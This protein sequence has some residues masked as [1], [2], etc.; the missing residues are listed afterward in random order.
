[1]PSR[2]N[3]PVS[4]NVRRL[5]I[6]L[7]RSLSQLKASL[8]REIDVGGLF[9]RSAVVHKWK[10]PWRALLLR[11]SVAWRI[12]DLISQSRQLS[13][14]SGILGARILLRSAFETVAVLVYLNKAMRSVVK[15]TLDFHLFSEKTARL[16]LGSRDKTTNLESIN[17]LSVLQSAN[18]RYPGL[19]SWYAALSESAHPNYE[20]MVLGYSVADRENHVTTF[21][22]RWAEMYGSSHDSALVACL[23]V[24][25]G[26]YNEEWPDAFNELEAWIERND[27]KL[28]ST[29]SGAGDA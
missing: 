24:F 17:I 11:E 10:A 29:K 7:D 2:R 21:E 16:L 12:H 23:I 15:E 6:D 1:M 5:M 22:N 25:E 14:T 13:S 4:S 8:C 18:S 26:E 28:E 3:G 9:T 20:G 27:D 19:E